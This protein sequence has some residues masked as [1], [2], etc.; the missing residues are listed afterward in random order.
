MTIEKSLFGKTKDGIEVDLYTLKDGGFSVEIIT[1]GATIRSIHAPIAGGKRDI[2]LGFDDMAGYETNKS[3]QGAVIGRIGNRVA[4]ARYEMNGKEYKMDVNDGPNCLHGGFIGLDRQVWSAAEE[5][6]ALVLTLLDKEGTAAGLPGNLEVKTKYTLEN[7]ELGIEYIATC[8]DDTPIN[9]TNHCYFNLAG[10]DAGSIVNHKIQIFSHK[11]TPV[12]ETLIPTGE[13]MDVTGTPFD[14]RELTIINQ[15][16]D[17]SDKQ[18]EL[19]GGYDHNWVLSNEPYRALA[20]AAVL[21]CDGL[22]MACLTTK[23]GIQLYTGNMMTPETGKG[24]A[25]YSKR[26]GVCLET[27]YFP[28]SVNTPQFPAPILRKGEVYNHKTVYRF[29]EV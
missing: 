13:L 5:Q 4:N 19:G 10:H 16:I 7:G 26:T 18:I 22:S 15:G 3:Y 6:G 2:A 23:P 11:I 1:Y 25:V 8:D 12:D 29:R 21:E 14:L 27:Q 20:I 24:G 28:N 17:S 9:L